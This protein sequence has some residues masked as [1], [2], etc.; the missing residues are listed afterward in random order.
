MAD[1]Y[2]HKM[3]E[4]F[5][6]SETWYTTS[7]DG[8]TEFVVENVYTVAIETIIKHDAESWNVCSSLGSINKEI[9]IKHIV[10]EHK[11]YNN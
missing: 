4:A 10:Y 5:S 11:R 8:S 3:E 6:S 2:A 1:N 7:R 9:S